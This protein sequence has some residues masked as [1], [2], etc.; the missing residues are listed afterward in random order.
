MAPTG[1]ELPFMKSVAM[2]LHLTESISKL[3]SLKK[4]PLPMQQSL[5]QTQTFNLSGN[6]ISLNLQIEIVGDANRRSEHEGLSGIGKADIEKGLPSTEKEEA[7]PHL[8]EYNYERREEESI[9]KLK[10]QLRLAELGCSRLQEQ[11]QT[12]RLRW[13]EEHHRAKILEEYAPTGIS[14]YP[15]RQIEW[16]APSPIQ[17]DDGYDFG[18]IDANDSVFLASLI[19]AVVMQSYDSKI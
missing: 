15:P 3:M 9:T 16:D 1:T 7:P 6:I 11:Y 14:T 5:R 17:S 8:P 13:L 18:D 12:Y 10:E 19:L 4:S 2:N